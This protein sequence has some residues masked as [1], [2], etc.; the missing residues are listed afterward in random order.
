MNKRILARLGT[1]EV[2]ITNLVSDNGHKLVAVETTDGSR[3]FNKF[4]F[5]AGS[6]YDDNAIVTYDLLDNVR[7]E[8]D[9][10]Q[11]DDTQ[12]EPEEYEIDDAEDWRME[13]EA[14]RRGLA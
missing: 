5:G 6:D 9:P 3:P 12:P 1:H 7:V 8:D 2:E 14:L 4:Y 10:F 11:P 13:T